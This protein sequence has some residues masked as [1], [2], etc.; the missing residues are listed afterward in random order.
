[1]VAEFLGKPEGKV[2]D[3]IDQDGLPAVSINADSRPVLKI[4]FSPLLRWLNR[5]ARNEPMT[6]DQLEAELKRCMA[7]VAERDRAKADRAKRRREKTA[8]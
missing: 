3:L 2:V 5:S 4:Y 8:A 6:E 7:A 1:M